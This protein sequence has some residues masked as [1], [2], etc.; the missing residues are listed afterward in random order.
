MGG[1][2]LKRITSGALDIEAKC[3]LNKLDLDTLS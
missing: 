3:L 1:S 2:G